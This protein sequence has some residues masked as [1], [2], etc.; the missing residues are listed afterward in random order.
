MRCSRTGILVS[1]CLALSLSGCDGLFDVQ[2]P[3]SISREVLDR[4]EMLA[5]MLNVPEAAGAE[6]FGS[7]VWLSGLI[8]DELMEPGTCSQRIVLDQGLIHADPSFTANYYDGL[9]EDQWH[10]TE[11]TR[12]ISEGVDNPDSHP[13]VA[14]GHYWNAVIM[15]SRADLFEGVT[16]DGGPLHSPAEVYQMALDLLQKAVTV[17]K[18]AGETE[19]VAA[20]YGTMARAERSLFFETGDGSHLAS[21][22][23]FAAQ[24][25]ATK[26]D[27]RTDARYASSGRSNTLYGTTSRYGGCTG[28]GEHFSLWTDPA[29]GMLDPRIN[30]GEAEGTGPTGDIFQE[31]TKFPEP[32]SPIS[33]SRWQEAALIIAEH[34]LEVGDLGGAVER[35]NDVR[36]AAGLPDFQSTDPTEIRKQLI[37][38]RQSEFFLEGR[39]WTDHRYYGTFPSRWV[40][41]AIAAGID[42]RVLISERER[43]SNENL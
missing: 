43:E 27:F 39:G 41:P 24:A 32:D 4:P 30:V 35:I 13:A 26:P 18:A 33:V 11:A 38:E 15:L 1:S 2:N 3:G 36:V 14:K 42:R 22:A 28:V 5:A 17:A 31:Y 34:R 6:N 21:A 16:F 19:Y 29:S 7:F 25:L 12:R 10:A 8:A 20:A 40:G 9:A 23:Q 37:H